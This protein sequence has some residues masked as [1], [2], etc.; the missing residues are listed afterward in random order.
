MEYSWNRDCKEFLGNYACE[1]LKTE[2]YKDCS[3]C[4]FHD[5]IE[6][7]ILI[8]KLGAKGD[9]IRTLPLLPAIKKK[10]PTS[11]ITWLVDEG[12]KG[13]L[14]NNPHIDKILSFN[15]ESFLRLNQEYFDILYC[16]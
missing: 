13:S 12:S 2:G 14:Q 6:K 16:L 10:Y 4:K 9:V 8:I 3:E 11:H 1:V 7:K 15:F 5:P